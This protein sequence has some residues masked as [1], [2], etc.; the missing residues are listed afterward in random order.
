MQ[1]TQI[2]RVRNIELA[3]QIRDHLLS[4]IPDWS[5]VEIG[6]SRTVEIPI[7]FR[8]FSAAVWSTVT[9]HAI[10]ALTP[11]HFA[12]MPIIARARLSHT[13]D[14]WHGKKVF[15]LRWDKEST[16]LITFYRGTWVHELLAIGAHPIN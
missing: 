9:L 14:I 11:L 5:S 8:I 12:G 7:E 2:V 3:V 15:S 13:L 6:V 4:R 1:A 16:E 10:E